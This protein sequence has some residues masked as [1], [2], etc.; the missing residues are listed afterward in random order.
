MTQTANQFAQARGG[1]PNH[2]RNGW[3]MKQPLPFFK[4]KN[5]KLP[6]WIQPSRL[7]EPTKRKMKKDS[8]R[9]CVD[10]TWES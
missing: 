6:L 5:D 2:E 10:M 8:T 7:A 9:A 4:T 1:K 3:N